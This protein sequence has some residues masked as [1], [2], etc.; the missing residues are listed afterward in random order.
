MLMS[1]AYGILDQDSVKIRK[2]CKMA[3]NS[4]ESYQV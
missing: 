2:V 1:H 4:D 3:N